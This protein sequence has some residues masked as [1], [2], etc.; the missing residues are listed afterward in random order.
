MQETNERI[1]Y[2]PKWHQFKAKTKQKKKK[3]KDKTK[4]TL[5]TFRV[6]AHKICDWIA[7]NVRYADYTMRDEFPSIDGKMMTKQL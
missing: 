3:R 7:S 2:T 6:Y 5:S 4:Q 1:L